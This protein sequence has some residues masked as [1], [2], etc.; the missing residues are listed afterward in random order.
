MELVSICKLG[1]SSQCSTIGFFPIEASLGKHSQN[2]FSV[3]FDLTIPFTNKGR[4]I[5]EYR[6]DGEAKTK[7]VSQMGLCYGILI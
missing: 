1:F 4:F 6:W 2:S 7:Y 5:K 3:H